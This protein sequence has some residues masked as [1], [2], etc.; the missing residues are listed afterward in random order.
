MM[1]SKLKEVLDLVMEI[2][3]P[4]PSH[5]IISSQ[6]GK[7]RTPMTLHCFNRLL[8]GIMKEYKVRYIGDR[9]RNFLRKLWIV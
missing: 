9:S 1:S 5:Y 7:G 6:K 2:L 3:R 8:K 4:V